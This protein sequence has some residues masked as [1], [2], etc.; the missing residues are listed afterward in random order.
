MFSWHYNLT[1]RCHS[2]ALCLGLSDLPMEVVGGGKVL[3]NEVHKR[4]LTQCTKMGDR[5]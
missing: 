2:K 3:G 5:K 1:L 4:K